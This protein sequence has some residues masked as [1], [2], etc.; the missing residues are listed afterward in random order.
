[1]TY[2]ESVLKV[3]TV[4]RGRKCFFSVWANSHRY[5]LPCASVSSRGTFTVQW[6]RALTGESQ[7]KSLCKINDL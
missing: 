7:N 4:L 3:T 2:R 1:V 6:L 5:F